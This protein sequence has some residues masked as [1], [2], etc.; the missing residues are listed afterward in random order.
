[1][2]AVDAA[3]G[4]DDSDVTFPAFDRDDLDDDWRHAERRQNRPE[5]SENHDL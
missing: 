5:S 2:V 4:D 3:A 1:V